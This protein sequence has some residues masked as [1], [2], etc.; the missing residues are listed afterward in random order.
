MKRQQSPVCFEPTFCGE[1]MP[2][3]VH[4]AVPLSSAIRDARSS[5]PPSAMAF[6][7]K[8]RAA[9]HAKTPKNVGS[10]PG[11]TCWSQLR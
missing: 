8:S 9:D 10:A 5:L 2:L 7:T 4:L 11:R 6:S 1:W 3:A